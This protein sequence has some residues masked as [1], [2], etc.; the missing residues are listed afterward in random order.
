MALSAVETIYNLAVSLVG[1]AL[2]TDNAAGR[3][4]KAF[5]LCEQYYALARDKM[6]SRHNWN[7]AV[8]QVIV[9]QQADTSD[10]LFEYNRKYATPSDSLK[11]ISVGDRNIYGS[12]SRGDRWPWEVAG[13]YIF[14]NAD[15]IPQTWITETDYVVG[16]YISRPMEVWVALTDYVVGQYVYNSST[17]YVCATA[18]TAGAAF[19]TTN[20][21]ETTDETTDSVSYVCA[22]AHEAGTFADDLESTYWTTSGVNY[23][24]IYVTY[25]QQ[26]TDTTKW[27]AV[28]KDAIAHQLALYIYTALHNDPKGKEA[29][30]LELEQLI[31][32]QA[33][34]VDSQQGKPK[35]LF[36]SRHIR[37]RYQGGRGW[38]Y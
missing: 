19:A 9:A 36:S 16:E 11:V 13:D 29:L 6:L 20:W 38:Y 37:S 4:S 23:R 24:I 1:D 26:L 25:I 7:E 33:R 12:P 8:T 10:P 28:L 18:H 30:L 34:S 14:S 22:T 31:L 27:G 21:T 2:I 3:D 17:T 5:K 32:P 15:Q 35:Q